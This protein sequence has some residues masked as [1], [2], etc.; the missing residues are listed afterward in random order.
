M[1]VAVRMKVAVESPHAGGGRQVHLIDVGG[2]V[3]PA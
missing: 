3:K 1:T 2:I